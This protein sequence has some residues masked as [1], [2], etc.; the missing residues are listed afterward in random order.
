MSKF[1]IENGILKAY[2]GHDSVV[3]V[4]E[5][6]THIGGVRRGEDTECPPI[7]RAK[8]YEYLVSHKAP[9]SVI[10]EEGC[11]LAEEMIIYHYCIK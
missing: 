2:R 9:K 6:V 8:R 3:V 10:D 11:G 7:L 5:G 1:V 4:P